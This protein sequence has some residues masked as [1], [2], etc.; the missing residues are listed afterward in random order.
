MSFVLLESQDS[1]DLMEWISEAME[2]S[3]YS[4]GLQKPEEQVV[5]S[6]NPVLEDC[7]GFLGLFTDHDPDW[8]EQPGCLESQP[9]CHA[10]QVMPNMGQTFL[11][12]KGIIGS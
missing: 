8:T 1:G 7:T 2:E 5:E 3:G 10:V 6:C 4:T 11:F 12:R 9:G